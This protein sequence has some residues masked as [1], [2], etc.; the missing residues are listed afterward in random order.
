MNAT[1]LSQTVESVLPLTADEQAFIEAFEDC[2]LPA[3]RFRHRDHVRLGWLYFRLYPVPAALA[4]Y[5]E[6]L[7]RFAAANGQPGLYHE[8]ITYAFLFLINERMER[9]GRDV[10]WDVFAARNADLT[11]SGLAFLNNYYRPETLSS[12]LA[13][14]VFLLP[15]PQIV[16]PQMGADER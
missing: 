15:E 11:S 4:R 13:R 6:G 14:K 16:Q 5:V 12:D 7:K 8:T 1:L 9:Q 3:D 10:S 2:T